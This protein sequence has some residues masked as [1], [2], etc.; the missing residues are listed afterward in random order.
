MK[1]TQQT[2]KENEGEIYKNKYKYKS[3]LSIIFGKIIV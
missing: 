1:D 2:I 3:L